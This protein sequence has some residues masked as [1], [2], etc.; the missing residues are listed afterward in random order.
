MTDAEIQAEITK[1]IRDRLALLAAKLRETAGDHG[2]VVRKTLRLIADDID[3]L[4]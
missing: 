2:P 3:G 4:A 1:Q